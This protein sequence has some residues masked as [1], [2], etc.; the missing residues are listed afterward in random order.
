MCEGSCGH[1]LGG[2]TLVK[3]ILHTRYKWPNINDDTVNFKKCDAC[4]QYVNIP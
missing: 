2:P 3:K 4:Q 1:H